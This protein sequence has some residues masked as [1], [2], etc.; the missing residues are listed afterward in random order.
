[1]STPY[2]FPFT[3]S[4]NFQRDFYP[5]KFIFLHNIV[6]LFDSTNVNTISLLFNL[7]TNFE[8]DFCT[9][10]FIFLH[11]IIFLFLTVQMSTPYHFRFTLSANFQRD[12]YTEKFI[13]LHNILLLFHSTNVNTIS[14]PFYSFREFSKRLLHRNVYFSSQHSPPLRHYQCQHHITS[15]LIFLLIFKETFTQKN[16]FFLTTFSS[17]LTVPMSTPYHFPFT[18]SANFQRD[19]H[20]E[21][22]IFLH[23][24]L[25]VFNSTNVNTISLPFYSFC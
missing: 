19:F 8:R 7:S 24:I 13:F 14:L 20:T 5:G 25:L 3:L 21:K 4:A 12:F 22:F 9:E 15:L 1:M 16:L 2:H 6:L 17:S 23:N 11:N 18:L 10:K